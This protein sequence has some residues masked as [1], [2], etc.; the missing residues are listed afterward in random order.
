MFPGVV[1][2]PSTF[3]MFMMLLRSVAGLSCVL[4]V[5]LAG[6][7]WA[8]GHQMNTELIA[9]DG[10]PESSQVELVPITP[11]L[12]AV[13]S[14]NRTRPVIAAELLAF[15]PDTYHIG[16][17]DVL[18]ITV[19]D[20][21][22]LTAPSGT[23]LQGDANGRYVG[24]DGVLFYPYAGNIHAAG[25]TVEE[26]RTEIASRLTKYIDNPQ[27][28]VSVLRFGS[29]QVLLSGAFKQT[30]PVPVTTKPLTLMEVLGIAGIDTKEADLSSLSLVRD[31]KSYQLDVYAL[32]RE[33]SD[34]YQLFVKNG[35]SIHLPY[36]DNNKVYVMGEILRPQAL[37]FKAGSMN[38]TDAIGSAGGLE[39]MTSKGQ[40]VYVIRGVDNLSAEK[41][42]IFQLQAKS[43]SAFV[44]AGKFQLQ[45]QDVV[46]VGA[47][48]ITR[49]NRVI[50]QLLPSLNVLGVTAG[51]ANEIDDLGN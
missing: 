30:A 32:T 22:E 26:L 11:K 20:H 18:F 33:P 51:A 50:S 44:L 13:D 35:D 24:P 16:P 38:L 43:P 37:T 29:Q 15:K 1:F 39:Q 25:K 7:A 19:W 23:Q 2:T 42:K 27:V 14:S 46:Y 48:G 3:G 10:S 45:P 21:P 49:W 9:N 17:A 12:I 47:A 6:C 8:P 40:D 36:N 4:S 28:D 41:A 34:I 31:G 5:L